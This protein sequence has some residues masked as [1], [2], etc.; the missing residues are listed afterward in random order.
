MVALFFLCS[1]LFFVFSNIRPS[2]TSNIKSAFALEGNDAIVQNVTFTLLAVEDTFNSTAAKSAEQLIETLMAYANW[3]NNT[4]SAGFKY[5]SYIQ[6]LSAVEPTNIDKDCQPFYEG[7][8]TK[9]SLMDEMSTFFDEK[10]PFQ[11]GS[12]SVRIFY[13]A[14]DTCKITSQGNTSYCLALDQPVYDWELDQALHKSGEGDL[15]DTL[16]IL[17]ACYSGGFVAKLA[18]PGRII[19][20]ACSPDETANGQPDADRENPPDLSWFTGTESATYP[21]GTAFGPLGMIGGITNVEDLNHDGWG[22]ADEI[23]RFASQTVSWYAANQTNAENG[24]QFNMDPWG[25]FGVAGGAIPL[26]QYDPSTPFPYDGKAVQAPPDSSNP[27]RYDSEEFRYPMYRYSPSHEDFS[28]A[29]GPSEPTVLWT[30]FLSDPIASSASVANGIVFVGTI[31]GTFYALELSTGETVWS[32]STG[33]SISSTPAIE[34]GLVIFGSKEPGRIYALDEYTGIVR[35][36]YKI[37]DGSSIFSSP[38][39]KDKRV[40]VT[41]SDGY[42]RSFTLFE[43]SLLWETY[44]GGNI[45][46]SPA[47]FGDTVCIAGIGVEAFDEFTGTQK[48]RIYFSWPVSSSPA[49]D[50]EAVYVGAENDD[51][52][53]ALNAITGIQLWS[54]K[55]GGWTSTPCIDSVKNLVIVGCRDTRVYCL[56]KVTGSVEWSYITGDGNYPSAPT[57]SS[58][59]LVYAGSLNGGLFCLNEDTGQKSM[60]LHHRGPCDF[61]PDDSRTT[62]ARRVFRR[63]PLLL[64]SS[65]ADTRCCDT[66]CNN[67]SKNVETRRACTSQLFSREPWRHG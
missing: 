10:L 40:F 33:T 12:L 31:G 22:S 9:A 38:T 58:D 66:E 56:D 13:Y 19:L 62:R 21:N 15:G 17:D 43:G 57:I 51:T 50:G 53:Y 41:S 35:W 26:V 63:L 24:Q 29:T 64:R 42:L 52:V 45:T 5:F 7:R 61:F 44:V 18:Q 23:F 36:T 4:V 20:T 65:A 60:E 59:G 37:P 39:I 6:L 48:W 46:A 49:V 8:T 16:V 14:G 32:F 55:R 67:L 2:S 28:K 1:T 34:D 27:Y 25:Y 47:V 11:N 54:S 30:H 3:R